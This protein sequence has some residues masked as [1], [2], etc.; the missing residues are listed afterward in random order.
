MVIA[1]SALAASNTKMRPSQRLGH[2]AGGDAI[3][4]HY[5]NDKDQRTSKSSNKPFSIMVSSID[6]FV[7]TRY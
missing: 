1:K 6:M 5:K 3:D 2:T 4:L 7:A